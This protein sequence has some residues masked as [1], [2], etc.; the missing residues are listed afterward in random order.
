M[1]VT[2]NIAEV[3]EKISSAGERSPYGQDVT[4]VAVSKTHTTKV[5]KEAYD[6][7]IRDF[8]ENKVQELLSK[9][10]V[11]PDDIRWHFIGHLQTNK[12][13]QI[14]DKAYLIHSVDSLHLAKKIDSEAEKAG[15]IPKILIEVNVA[16]EESKYGLKPDELMDFIREISILKNIKTEGLMTVAPYTENAEENRKYFALLR[17]LSIDI[18]GL[19]LDNISMN[20]LSMGMSGDYSVAI[21]EGANIIRIGTSIFGEREYLFL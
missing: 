4:L 7:G 2:E 6:S 16:E 13:K 8:G 12:V 15:I 19:N 18:K 11:L 20:F 14:I 1:S 10:E 9:Y 5:I 17:K 21:E 3:K